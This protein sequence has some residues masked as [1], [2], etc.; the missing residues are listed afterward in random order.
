MIQFYLWYKVGC[1]LPMDSM[2][3]LNYR[4]L[5]LIKMSFLCF[6]MLFLYWLTF[7]AECRWMRHFLLGFTNGVLVSVVAIPVVPVQ[8]EACE[9]QAIF[10]STTVGLFATPVGVMEGLAGGRPRPVTF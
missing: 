4:W 2:N 1:K 10:S 6:K 7:L 5:E 9:H 3:F 8:I